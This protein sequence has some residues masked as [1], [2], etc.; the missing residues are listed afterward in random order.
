ML[1]RIISIFAWK[2]M[3]SSKA[4]PCQ[5]DAFAGVGQL[6]GVGCRHLLVIAK[7]TALDGAGCVQVFRDVDIPNGFAV[8]EPLLG[9]NFS[10]YHPVKKGWAYEGQR[11]QPE[12]CQDVPGCSRWR[13]GRGHKKASKHG[14][15]IAFAGLP[16]WLRG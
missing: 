14:V 2:N 12:T 5:R 6:L 10:E 1:G 7:V 9:F 4:G 3:A 13:M 15:F 11:S 16:N 8:T